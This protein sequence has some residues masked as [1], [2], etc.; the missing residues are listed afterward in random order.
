[1]F[2]LNSSVSC[3]TLTTNQ[4]VVKRSAP[5]QAAAIGSVITVSSPCVEIAPANMSVT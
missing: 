2:H 5:S 4:D 1:V 3:L